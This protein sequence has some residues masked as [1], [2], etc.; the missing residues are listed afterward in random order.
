ML[1]EKQPDPKDY[2]HT[3]DSFY[4]KCP[5]ERNPETE[6]KTLVARGE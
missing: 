3:V 1:S 5:K 6:R 4:M 2:I